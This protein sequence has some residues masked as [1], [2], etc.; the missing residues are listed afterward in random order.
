MGTQSTVG[1]SVSSGFGAF[2]PVDGFCVGG[3]AV[4]QAGDELGV[5]ADWRATEARTE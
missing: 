1:S 2:P 5:S 3:H 4:E